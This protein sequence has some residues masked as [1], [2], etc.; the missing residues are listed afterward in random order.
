M[1]DTYLDSSTPDQNYGNDAELKVAAGQHILVFPS[2]SLWAGCAALPG[3]A[4]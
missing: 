3:G 1:V 2:V 4:R